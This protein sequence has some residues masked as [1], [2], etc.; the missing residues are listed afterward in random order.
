MFTYGARSIVL[1]AHHSLVRAALRTS[2]LLDP[3]ERVAQSPRSIVPG[4]S[5]GATPDPLY[6]IEL[7]ISPL[8]DIKLFL[9]TDNVYALVS[10]AVG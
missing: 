2:T 7:R 10:Y 9:H 3:F 1:S 6:P 4:V 8:G 5:P